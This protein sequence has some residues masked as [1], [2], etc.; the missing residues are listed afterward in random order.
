MSL[1][2]MRDEG[3]EGEWNGMGWNEMKYDFIILVW[4]FYDSCW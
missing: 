2:D 4:V 3:S 1:R